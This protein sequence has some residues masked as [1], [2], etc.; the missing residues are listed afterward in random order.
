MYQD[1]GEQLP[2]FLQYESIFQGNDHMKRVLGLI[3]TDILDFH[4]KAVRYFSKT[5]MFTFQYI[6]ISFPSHLISPFVLSSPR[7]ILR[8]FLYLFSSCPN[9]LIFR[10]LTNSSLE[11][12]FPS[13]LVNIPHQVLGYN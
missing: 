2:I 3:Y 8:C 12:A 11:T 7:L 5:G 1:I 13:Y 10:H 6:Y 9:R 4:A